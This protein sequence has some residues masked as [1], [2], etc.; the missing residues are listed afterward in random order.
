MFN[1][2]NNFEAYFKNL[3]YELTNNKSGLVEL[4]LSQKNLTDSHISQLVTALQ[5]NTN[6]KTL[7]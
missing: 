2:S 3:L 5:Q 1:A 4:N 7:M 6:L